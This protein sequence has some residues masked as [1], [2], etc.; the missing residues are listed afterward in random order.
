MELITLSVALFTPGFLFCHEFSV[1]ETPK[2]WRKKLNA[3][4]KSFSVDAYDHPMKPLTFDEV[5]KKSSFTNTCLGGIIFFFI[6]LNIQDACFSELQYACH[7]LVWS[8]FCPLFYVISFI[9]W[10]IGH[11][12]EVS[13]QSPKKHPHWISGSNLQ[14]LYCKLC[15]PLWNAWFFIL[16]LLTSLHFF[17][18]LPFLHYCNELLS[19]RSVLT[20][21]IYMLYIHVTSQEDIY[22][23][24]YA[25]T[26]VYINFLAWRCPLCKVGNMKNAHVGIMSFYSLS[27]A[28]K[29]L[30]WFSWSQ[31][32]YVGVGEKY[33]LSCRFRFW[34][35]RMICLNSLFCSTW[36]DILCVCL[37]KARLCLFTILT[38]ANEP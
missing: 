8:F 5:K 34:Y 35:G 15:P 25:S 17:S 22:T 30:H 12:N 23:N 31:L 38:I 37:S 20:S 6:L 36:C 7:C 24:L 13:C 9:T 16:Q 11:V 33:L 27:Y 14:L 32:L 10:I 3:R 26:C 28:T 19:F 1:S 4:L 18:H 29:S 21:D 2:S